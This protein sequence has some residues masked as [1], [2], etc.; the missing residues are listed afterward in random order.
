MKKVIV[1]GAGLGGLS[2]AIKLAHHGFDVS[3]LEKEES[4]GGKLCSVEL[5]DYQFDLGP[6]TITLK[7]VFDNVFK[8]V[9]RDP[10]DYLTFYPIEKGTRNFFKDGHV[11]DFSNDV[12]HVQTQISAFSEADANNYPLFLDEAKRLYTISDRQFFSQLMYPLS[13]KL[14]PS[15]LKDFIKIKPL[16]TLNT[17]VESYFEHPNTR[18]LFNRYA[19]YIG[20]SPYQAP[21]IFGMMAHLEGGQGIWG[22][23]G[24]SYQIVRAFERLAR[25]LGVEFFMEH[26]VENTIQKGNRIVGVQAN[27]Q[28]FAADYVVFNADALTVYQNLLKH[29]PLNRKLEKKEVSLSGFAM[30]LGINKTYPELEHHNVFFPKEYTQEFK[31]IFKDKQVPEE[32]TIYICQS[33][34]SEPKRAKE[35]GGNLFILI[36]APY[37]SSN[38]TWN[39]ETKEKMMQRV[40]NQL[41]SYGLD[42]L[43]TRIDEQYCMTPKDIETR[44]GAF[45]GSLYGLSS[46]TIK[47]AFFRIENKDPVLS[48]VYFAGGSTHPG[49]GTPMVTLSGQLVASDIIG[50]YGTIHTDT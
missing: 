46:N 43:S 15:L 16:T 41:E 31:A 34:V 13:T 11:V 10:Q 18:M 49:G 27:G 35:G 26:E 48:N 22:V 9:G 14:S 36:N 20:S 19:T 1:V 4:C 12:E 6:S 29:H 21:M 38:L 17:L 24:G 37:L 39:E 3:V 23:E 30:L 2:A 44:T 8:S 45:K 28:T 33:S 40:I 25:E 47:Q 5:G 50:I 42:G 32:P 7:H